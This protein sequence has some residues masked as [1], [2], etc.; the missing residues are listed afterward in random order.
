LLLQELPDGYILSKVRLGNK[1]HRAG[2][3]GLGVSIVSRY[4]VQ[5]AL[6]LGRVVEVPLVGLDLARSL[7]QLRHSQGPG[8]FAVEAFVNFISDRDICKRFLRE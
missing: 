3:A 8:G 5:E 7:Y 6:E 2:E 1:Y 4:A